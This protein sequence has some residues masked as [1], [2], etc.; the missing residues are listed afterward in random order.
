M[1][2]PAWYGISE[3]NPI[4]WTAPNLTT[5]RRG[6]KIVPMAHSSEELRAYKSAIA[7]AFIEQNPDVTPW[8]GD[9]ELEFFLW[10]CLER[11]ELVEARAV[12]HHRVDATNMQKALEDALQGLLYA[13]DRNVRDI[14]TRIMAQG[15]EVEPFILV[16]ISPLT[17]DPMQAIEAMAAYKKRQS[18]TRHP[19]GYQS[20]RHDLDAH[21]LF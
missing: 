14:R 6:G 2:E 16:H 17:D 19:S 18:Q 11:D 4:P 8:E 10:R 7:D 15:P 5:G 21:D 12:R 13:N 1:K 20:N 3:V 9:I